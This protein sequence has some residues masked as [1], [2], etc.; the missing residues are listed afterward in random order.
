M[1]K[2]FFWATKGLFYCPE[3]TKLRA[4]QHQIRTNFSGSARSYMLW[5]VCSVEQYISLD[6]DTITIPPE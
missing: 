2:L 3:S 1:Q 6:S 5:H 4:L